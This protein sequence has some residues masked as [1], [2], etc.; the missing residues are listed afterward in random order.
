MF[1]KSVGF[2]SGPSGKEPIKNGLERG[3]PSNEN[4]GGDPR[5]LLSVTL[6]V[7]QLPV[8]AESN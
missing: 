7:D 3:G 5:N 2:S 8:G 1:H 4:F 6:K